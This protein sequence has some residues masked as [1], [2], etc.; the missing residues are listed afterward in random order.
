MDKILNIALVGGGRIAD[1]HAPGYLT[2]SHAKLYALCDVS[3]AVNAR[4]KQE[5]GL[6]KTYTSYKELLADPKVDA[7]EILTP[8][9]LHHPM[10]IEAAAAGKHVSVQK[11]MAMTLKECDEMIAACKKAGVHFKV[12]ENFV[13]Y[14]PYIRAR[15]IIENGD[16]GDPLTIRTRLGAGYGGW[17]IP[18]RAWA[19]RLN[20][21]ESGGGPTIFD[22]GYHKLSVAIDFFGP[23]A[24]VTGWVD[25]TLAVVD[26][27][28]ALAWKHASGRAGYLDAALTPGVFVDGKYYTAD[29]RVEITG[30]K[31]VVHITSCT[32]YPVEAPPVI[33]M[34]DGRVTAHTDLRTDWMA[35][36][37]DSAQDFAE[38]ILKNRP[39][40]LTGE[41]GRD[42]T[43]FALA[44]LE[45]GAKNTTVKP[46]TIDTRG[47]ALP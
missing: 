39:P 2:S 34:T 26:S 35:S 4:R 47:G 3:E 15:K 37:S 16:I 14:P 33:V 7:V 10:V 11:P 45:A 44:C 30:T 24:S 43:A 5:W 28:A 1:M 42:V 8:H 36:F 9:H 27:P 17:E 21:K 12:F 40:H 20:E 19:W 32:G 25:R 41:R 22:D 6:E 23:I 18:L 46:E 31:G 38:A 29:E 13:F